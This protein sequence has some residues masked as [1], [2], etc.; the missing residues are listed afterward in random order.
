MSAGVRVWLLRRHRLGC[1][2]GLWAGLGRAMPDYEVRRE[3]LKQ[4]GRGYE[5]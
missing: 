5:W 2:Y 1:P 4:V 3:R